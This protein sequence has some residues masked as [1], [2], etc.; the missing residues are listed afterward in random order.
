MHLHD[1]SFLTVS[2]PQEAKWALACMA[3]G[4]FHSL[5]VRRRGAPRVLPNPAASVQRP[6]SSAANK[7][8]RWQDREG[9]TEHGDAFVKVSSNDQPIGSGVGEGL[10]ELL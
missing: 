9:D 8:P 6:L 5:P 1:A 4:R 7:W 3:V 10:K 2:I